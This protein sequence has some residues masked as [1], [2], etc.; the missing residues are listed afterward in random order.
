MRGRFLL[1]SSVLHLVL[2]ALAWVFLCVTAFALDPNKKITQYLHNAWTSEQ[3]LPENDVRSIVQT[4][5]GYL[6]LA[7]EEGLARFDGVHFKVFDKHSVDA[8]KNNFIL[9]LFEDSEGTLW[10]GSWGGGLTRFS[11]GRFDTYTKSDG[12]G[13]DIVNAITQDRDGHI[14][15]GT[16]G[17]GLDVW[18][19]GKFTAYTTKQGLSHNRVLALY[20]SRD[21]SLWIGSDGGLDRLRDGKVAAPAQP[22]DLKKNGVFALYEDEQGVLWIGSNHGLYSYKDGIFT[23]IK[24]IPRSNVSV[25]YKDRNHSLFVGTES[26][27]YRLH[28]GK[29]ESYTVRDG[30]TAP[31]VSSI[32]EDREGSLWIGTVFGGLDRLRDG[33]LT[34]Y[35]TD[36]GLANNAA[37]AILQTKGGDVWIGTL[38]GGLSKFSKG[39]FE[40]FGRERGLASDKIMT[41]AEGRDG[42]L[43]VGTNSGLNYLKNGTVTSFA[44][45]LRL[46]HS[47]VTAVLE[48]SRGSVWFGTETALY[49][50][51]NGALS[52]FTAAQ[53]LSSGFV[54]CLFEDDRGNVWVGT[55]K[56]INMYRDGQFR[57]F[58][59]KEAFAHDFITQIHQQAPN[60]LWVTTQTAGIKSLRDG[61]VTSI[62]RDNGLP[63]DTTWSL[64]FD[65]GG[66]AWISSN[67]GIFRISR[68]E[69]QDIVAGKIKDVHPIVYGWADGMKSSECNGAQPA[70]WRTADGKLWFPTTKGVVVI[71]PEQVAT[72]VL[73]P[74]VYIEEVLVK[75]RPVTA[76]EAA[77]LASGS[78]NMEIRYTGLSLL[79]PEKVTFRYMLE[80]LDKT[81]MDAGTRRTAYYSYLPPGKYRFRVTAANNDGVWSQTGATYAFEVRPAFYQT[82]WFYLSSALA[83][84]FL[85]R[86]LYRR[87][88]QRLKRRTQELAVLSDALAGKLQAE[89]RYHDL[90]ES[91]VYAI[92]RAQGRRYLEVNRAMVT[93]LGYT[94]KEEVLALIPE[95]EVYT[96]V[97]DL[98]HITSEL[99]AVGKVEGFEAVWKRKDGRLI[100][101]RLSGLRIA[102][103]QGGA[104]TYEVIAQDVT[105]RK[106]LEEQLRQSQKMEAMGRLAGGIAHDF[107]NLLTVILGYTRIVLGR[108]RNGDLTELHQV[109]AAA[110]HAAALTGQLLAFSRQQVLQPRVLD[111]N[112]IVRNVESMLG[113]V[114]GEDIEVSTDLEPMLWQIKADRNQIAQVI[115][116]LAVNSRDAMPTGGRLRFVTQN[117]AEWDRDP[118]QTNAP[119]GPH[120]LLEVSDTGQG[121][122]DETLSHIFEPFFTTKDIGQ[123]TGLGL[124]TVYGIVQQSGGRV[125]VQSQPGRGT[126]F[127]IYLPRVWETEVLEEAQVAASHEMRGSETI[128]LVEDHAALRCLTAHILQGSGYKVL[129]AGSPNEAERIFREY[130]RPI[131]MILTDVIMPGDNGPELA[132]RLQQQR[133]GVRLMYVSGYVENPALR[134]EVLGHNLPFLQKPFEPAEM[135]T[136]VRQVLDSPLFQAQRLA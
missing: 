45:N 25:I 41:L 31:S 86:E 24:Q 98:D 40:T 5:D 89:G 106:Q 61:K 56:G 7:T 123:G 34:T 74:P 109:R 53:G 122:D 117:V 94:S 83:V 23:L 58:P 43:W 114:I 71:D 21:G 79:V 14:W 88:V 20:P 48:D 27:L 49:K 99:D 39:R 22:K 129:Q 54:I 85:L 6:W 116:N 64:L 4:R 118:E 87:N 19:D 126:T 37:T 72:N 120:V 115:M 100:Q 107:N 69:I 131:D 13:D 93:M 96:D 68:G 28:Q 30:L 42:G 105:E 16:G 2:M 127:R 26:G 91:A 112:A 63:H 128:L 82:Y 130:H 57:D 108:D 92:Y 50:L 67:K 9:S 97:R 46:P 104:D 80:G 125:Q 47:D 18:K 111:L 8:I 95:S 1:S 134:E 12:L 17:G 75:G 70:G 52:T 10:I 36:E 29:I 101:V 3:G 15:I 35:T 33:K 103:P 124:S 59:G 78:H 60:T 73:P 81:W 55:D 11:R 132:R 62:N 84:A 102:D 110:D 135:L 51:Q 90:F 133:P 119:P 66:D 113:R 76:V 121:M 136:K 38:G 32:F 65:N 77:H 44:R